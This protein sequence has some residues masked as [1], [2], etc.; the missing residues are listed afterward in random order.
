[1]SDTIQQGAADN[2]RKDW[3]GLLLLPFKA[4][5][6]VAYIFFQIVF[7][8]VSRKLRIDA[9]AYVWMGYTLCFSVFIFM[10]VYHAFTKRRRAALAKLG[11]AAAAGAL[12]WLMLPYLAD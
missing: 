4:Y 12:W 7:A 11:F 9:A 6:A 8:G 10:A 5:V 3:R 1:M 2:H